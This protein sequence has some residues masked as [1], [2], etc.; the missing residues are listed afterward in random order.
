MGYRN[1]PGRTAPNSIGRQLLL[2]ERAGL[3]DYRRMGDLTSSLTDILPDAYSDTSTITG[4][5]I[6][7]EIAL[8]AVGTM[9]LWSLTK[10][11]GRGVRRRYRKLAR[12][13]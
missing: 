12:R 7:W 3:G 8:G 13:F 9:V 10:K 2:Q 4:L 6:V 1:M 5:P 11:A